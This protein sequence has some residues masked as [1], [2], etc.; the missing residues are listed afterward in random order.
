MVDRC[1]EGMSM[2][3]VNAKRFFRPNARATGRN[4]ASPDLRLGRVSSLTAESDLENRTPP[5]DRVRTYGEHWSVEFILRRSSN[6]AT[7]SERGGS[8]NFAN[9]PQKASEAGRKGGQHS[10]QNSSQTRGPSDARCGQ[11]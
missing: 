7:R 9:D 6:M 11:Q 8:G 4:P 1:L 10:H 3:A 5:H 2:E